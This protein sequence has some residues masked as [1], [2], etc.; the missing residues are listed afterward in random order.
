MTRRTALSV[1]EGDFFAFSA[2][3][4]Q[5][6][7]R[8]QNEPHRGSKATAA[9]AEGNHNRRTSRYRNDSHAKGDYQGTQQPRDEQHLSSGEFLR[10]RCLVGRVIHGVPPVSRVGSVAVCPH[11]R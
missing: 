3:R 1:N 10:D 8:P 5:P 4:H 9:K 7:E 6:R 11:I 2:G